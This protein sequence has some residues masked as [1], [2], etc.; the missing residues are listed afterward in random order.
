MKI[1]IIEN[2]KSAYLSISLIDKHSL[3]KPI[4]RSIECIIV[5]DS[6]LLFTDSH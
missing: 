6:V 4:K 5:V 2:R 1:D 3:Y